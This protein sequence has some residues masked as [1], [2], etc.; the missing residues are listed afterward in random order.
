L[1]TPVNPDSPALAAAVKRGTPVVIV[2]RTRQDKLSC[3]VSV[4]DVHGGW[5]AGRHLLDRGHARVAFIGGPL[6]LGQVRE[7]LEGLRKAWEEAGQPAD[8]IVTL[9]TSALTVNEGHHAGERLIGLPAASRPTAAFCA[10]DLVALGLLRM[11]IG[12][13]VRVPEDLAIVGFDDI[14]FAAAAAVPLTSVRQPRVELGRRAA[15]LL[16]D[17]AS[18][19]AHT[20]EQVVFVPELVARA[21]SRS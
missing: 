12:A 19:P 21:S 9:P 18:N 2:D 15:E 5:I 13:G 8:G 1:I 14:D 6:E 20:H 10:N 7:R 3:S 4:D 17:E 11:A 16:I